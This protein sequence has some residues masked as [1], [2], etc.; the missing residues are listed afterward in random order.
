MTK[1]PRKRTT[2]ETSLK[3]T[4]K[5]FLDMMGI[6]HYSNLQGLG[7]TPGIPDIVAIQDG[8]YVGIEVK[9][10]NGKQSWHQK[11]FE[12]SITQAGGRYILAYSV[13]DV[14]QGMD[15]KQDILTMEV[16]S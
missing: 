5:A 7:A 12:E 9:A 15:L 6:F 2:P 13:E 4:I 8:I 14:I 11:A 16:K 1:Y 10:P 3:K